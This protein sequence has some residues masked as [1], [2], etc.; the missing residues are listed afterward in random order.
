M[1]YSSKNDPPTG[2]VCIRGNN[3]F[4]GYYKNPEKTAEDLDSDGWFHTGD[5]GRWNPTGTLS[6][7]DRKKNIFKLAQGEY[8]AA[9]HVEGQYIKCIYV[10]QVFIYGDSFKAELV[11]IV[12][13]DPDVLLK[14]A[15]ENGHA[16][17]DLATLCAKKEVVEFIHAELNKTAKENKLKGFE[18]AKAIHVEPEP[19]SAENELLTPTFK[20]KRPQLKNHYQP[21][22]DALYEHLQAKEDAKKN[23][24]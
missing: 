6:I 8:V 4:I 17:D 5:I 3:V 22:I 11:G 24:K 21:Q 23:A 16:G 2:E 18:F 13:P 15:G 14:W 20:P 19:F 7:I 12:V 1:N 10:Q 9:E